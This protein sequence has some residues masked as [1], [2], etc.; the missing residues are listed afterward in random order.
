MLLSYIHN[1]EN[2]LV[3][4][5]LWCKGHHS[6]MP[7]LGNRDQF[8]INCYSSP[9]I[10]TNVCSYSICTT[11]MV[12]AIEKFMLIISHSAAPA[13]RPHIAARNG[14]TAVLKEL[15]T[16]QNLNINMIDKVHK[17]LQLY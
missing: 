2:P 9:T 13:D 16:K 1:S 10:D 7:V 17:K 5:I 6:I 3:C 12:L 11:M 15:L 14:H 8:R 4:T